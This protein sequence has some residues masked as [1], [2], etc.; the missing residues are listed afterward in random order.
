MG[1]CWI[2]GIS[3]EETELSEGVL[4]G[5]IRAI[6]EKCAN[7]EGIPLIRKKRIFETRDDASNLSVK[8]RM[9]K[10]SDFKKTQSKENYVA[11]QNLAKLRFP[12][13]REDHPDLVENYDWAIKT[14][15]RR[16]KLSQTQVAEE[17]VIPLQVIIDLESGKLPPNFMTYVEKLEKFLGSKIIR[18]H[19][20]VTPGFQRPRN[21]EE[22]K[23]VLEEVREKMEGK[24]IEQEEDNE[25]DFKNREKLKKLTL[26]DLINFKRKKSSV[27]DKKFELIGDEVEIEE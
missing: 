19:Y 23:D 14:A 15:R 16:K 24:K 8:E 18:K 11:H 21:D 10:M 12:Q 2:C 6:C 27:D 26:R 7:Y 22:E 17:L 1:N 25:I 3:G 13:K 4:E 9:E 5:K 20:L